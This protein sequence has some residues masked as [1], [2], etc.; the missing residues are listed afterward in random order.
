VTFRG[1]AAA[2]VER[3]AP[4]LPARLEVREQ[5]EG[6][7]RLQVA[8]DRWETF[9]LD[10]PEVEAEIDPATYDPPYPAFAV[11][12]ALD[13]VQ[14]YVRIELDAEWE[15]GEP[16]AEL[17]DEEIRFGYAGGTTFEPIPL[18]ALS[19]EG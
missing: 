12:E 10:E 13:L 4:H 8:D 6:T 1:L 5:P 16:W 19:S 2:V 9:R 14:E 15:E 7:L 11:L 18:D 17:D 3:L